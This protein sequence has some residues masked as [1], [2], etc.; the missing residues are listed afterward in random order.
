MSLPSYKIGD[1]ICARPN[2]V[3]EG[4]GSIVRG[5]ADF[6]H[7]LY[8]DGRAAHRVSSGGVF[9]WAVRAQALAH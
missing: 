5:N 2:S 9:R 1:S 7:L 4:E 3:L 6:F 8:R